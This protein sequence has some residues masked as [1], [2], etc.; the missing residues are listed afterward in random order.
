MR[1]GD[2]RQDLGRHPWITVANDTLLDQRC[3]M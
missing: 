2:E 1:N 3:F